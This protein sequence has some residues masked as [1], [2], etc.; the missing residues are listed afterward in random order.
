MNIILCANPI[1]ERR[2]SPLLSMRGLTQPCLILG[3]VTPPAQGRYIVVLAFN[4]SVLVVCLETGEVL[5]R[6]IAPGEVT[7]LVGCV[8]GTHGRNG[9]D[10]DGLSSAAT[11]FVGGKWSSVV[12]YT[13][14]AGG[15]SGEEC[16]DEAVGRAGAVFAC[17]QKKTGR[18][19][20]TS[21]VR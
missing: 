1:S 9:S 5:Q 11:I 3:H 4:C 12:E 13:I 17:T 10:A 7:V 8:G 16:A 14:G 18:S 21:Y 2:C 20:S 15:G 6:I 19:D